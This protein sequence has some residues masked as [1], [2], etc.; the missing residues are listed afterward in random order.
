MMK[1]AF[2]AVVV[3]GCPLLWTMMIVPLIAKLFGVPIKIGSLPIHRQDQRLGKKQSFWF[4][5]LLGWGVGLSL[6]GGL[7]QRF[8]D[9]TRSTLPSLLL[10][11]AASLMIGGIASMLDWT[12]PLNRE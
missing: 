11:I 10:A 8:I 3:I 2:V 1:E 9:Q 12:Y 6:L 4:G 5:G 7:V